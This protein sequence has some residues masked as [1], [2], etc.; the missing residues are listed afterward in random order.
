MTATEKKYLI[1]RLDDIARHHTYNIKMVIIEKEKT[2]TYK[3]LWAL[4]IAGKL[5]P[6]EERENSKR[7]YKDREIN[8]TNY[9][10][11]TFNI[12]KYIS[13]P[14]YK[15]NY[16]EARIKIYEECTRVKDEI[17]LG[18]SKKGLE[19]IKAFQKKKF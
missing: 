3:E 10:H 8:N 18:S 7:R 4:I 14:V 16:D 13:A 2:I 1:K 11:L 12:N 9:I 6:I 15:L 5:K 17:M 19:L